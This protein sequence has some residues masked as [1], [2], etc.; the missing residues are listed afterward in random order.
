MMT[1]TTRKDTATIRALEVDEI[2]LV[3]GGALKFGISFQV[4]GMD[5]ETF[6]DDKTGY[7]GA[8]ARIIATGEQFQ[9]IHKPPV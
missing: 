9:T 3:G 1:E 5:I 8:S 4:A 2:D 7:A 6:Y